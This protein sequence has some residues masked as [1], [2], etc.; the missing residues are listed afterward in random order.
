MDRCGLLT[1]FK[2]PVP[3]KSISVDVIIRG[4][5]ADVVSELQYQNE[6]KN[7]VE[8]TFVFPLDDEAAVYAFE[9]LICGTRIEA[10]IREKKQAEQE[11]EDALSEGRQAFLLE[12]EKNTSDIFMCNLGNLPPGGEAT[13][14]L[15]YV[16][17]LPVEPDDA[18]RF[19][20]PAVLNPRYVPA[21]SE[22]STVFQQIPRVSKEALPYTLSLSA[23][24]ESQ[25]GINRV[26]SKCSLIQNMSEDRTAAQVSLAE[27]HQFD[28]DVELLIYY[29]DVHKTSAILETGK[30]GAAPGS[31]MGDPALLLSLYPNIPAAKADQGVLGE[32]IFLL[33]RSGSMG[34]TMGNSFGSQSRIESAKETL[35]FL[36]KSLPLGCYFNIYGFGSTYDSFYPQSVKYTQETMD[37]SVQRVKELRCDLGGTEIIKPLKAVYSQPCFEGHPRQIFVFTD[38]EVSNTDEVIAEVQRYSHFH[39]CFSFGI[40]EGASTALVKGIARAAGGSAEF[41]SGKERMQAKALQSLKKA[42]HPAVSGISLKW[43][44]PSGLEAKLVG[45]GP[46]V[47]FQG[48]RCLIYAQIRGQLQMS[49]SMEG[50][51]VIQYNFQNETHIETT[52]FSLQLEKTDRLP[53]HRLAA[54]ALLQELEEDKE[55]VEEKRVLALETSLS[56]GVVC[57]QTAYV[58]VNMELGKPVQGPLLHR[59]VP[60]PDSGGGRAPQRRALL[61]RRRYTKEAPGSLGAQTRCF[62]SGLPSRGL[63][64]AEIGGK[65]RE[66]AW[67]GHTAPQCQASLTSPYVDPADK[68]EK[69]GG[70]KQS[71][72]QASGLMSSPATMFC[73]GSS[74]KIT[75]NILNCPGPSLGASMCHYQQAPTLDHGISFGS[76]PRLRPK[77]WIPQKEVDV[78]KLL[79]PAKDKNGNR[80]KEEESPLMKLVSLQNADGSW[81][82]GPVVAAILELTEAEISGK[83][84]AHVAS[85]IWATVLAVLWLHLTA[86]EQ[87]D[88]WELLERKAV[89]WLKVNAGDQLAKCVNAGNEVLGSRISPKVFGL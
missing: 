16:Q 31:L 58:G 35:I 22:G 56:S 4:F 54:Q 78:R 65:P 85:D 8:A 79:H 59:N 74:H 81:P 71:N 87:K 68:T 34:S 86:T 25:Y 27:G 84:P 28:R 82:H 15:R 70:E 33:D 45:S 29:E 75:R 36:L 17:A 9:G 12:R 62:L 41:I 6:E 49:G 30:S 69:G 18:V 13:L 51:A 10:Q 80:T 88:E 3:L 5:V 50:T 43:E 14:K 77:K 21:G 55:K 38:G 53:V 89:H 61:L 64:G 2:V 24:V 83:A 37:T 47:I 40:G 11:Y 42:L 46:H 48:H 44:L 1:S 57:S 67:S 66:S 76:K 73:L 72:C 52:K 32:F 26:D 20:L 60:L 23:K 39:R 63:A 19:V 7:P